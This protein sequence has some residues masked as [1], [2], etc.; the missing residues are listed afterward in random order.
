MNACVALEPTSRGGNDAPSPRQEVAGVEPI[1][2]QKLQSTPMG[3]LLLA[4]AFLLL[5]LRDWRA[6][7][8]LW[9]AQLIP[10]SMLLR[11]SL[12]APWAWMQMLV[13]GFVALMMFFS[14]RGAPPPPGKTHWGWRIGFAALL[15][16]LIAHFRARIPAPWRS[17]VVI[18]SLAL[19]SAGNLLLGDDRLSSG[20]GLLMAWEVAILILSSLDLPPR[21]IG[22]LYVL[23]MAMGL[24]ISYLVVAERMEQ[25][26]VE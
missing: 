20:I 23:E 4:A 2:W 8:L 19:S 9:G 13:G 14:C 21:E 26:E 18:Q 12:P 1:L 5:I 7:L 17:D 11:A 16:L 10:V 24:A 22:V 15:I 6:Q 3:T 25:G